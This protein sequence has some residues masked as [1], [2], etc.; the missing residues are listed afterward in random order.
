MTLEITVMN[1][2]SIAFCVL[3]VALLYSAAAAQGV[4][5]GRRQCDAD[6]HLLLQR[7]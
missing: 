7:G 6:I 4:S 1:P 2:A 5:E 3:T